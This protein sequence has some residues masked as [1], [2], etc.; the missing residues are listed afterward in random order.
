MAWS[1][2]T[3][4]TK[5]CRNR[6]TAALWLKPATAGCGLGPY[7]DFINSGDGSGSG[8]T[9]GNG[10]TAFGGVGQNGASDGFAGYFSGPT[11]VCGSFEVLG[12]LNV[13]GGTK[14]FKIDHPLDPANKY[15]YH[16]AVE[17][18]TTDVP[19]NDLRLFEKTE[20]RD[21]IKSYTTD[22]FEAAFNA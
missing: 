21:A 22:T 17:R 16:A 7:A 18:S 2:V 15:L 20:M 1:S 3:R 14:N 10:I 9:A 19:T 5:D 4:S 12:N 8:Y 13:T 11:L 6:G